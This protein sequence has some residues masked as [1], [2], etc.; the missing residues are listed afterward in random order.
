LKND[1]VKFFTPIS[2]HQQQ[3]QEEAD[4]WSVVVAVVICNCCAFS[5]ILTEIMDLKILFL[6]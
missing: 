4:G 6:F 3:Q 1:L 5:F 2:S